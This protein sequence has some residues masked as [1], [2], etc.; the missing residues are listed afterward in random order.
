MRVFLNFRLLLVVLCCLG[1]ST[2]LAGSAYSQDLQ[3]AI[4]NNGGNSVRGQLVDIDNAG[5]V[6]ASGS[7]ALAADFDPGTPIFTLTSQGST[8]A[9]IQKLD[10]YGNFAWAKAIGGP[11]LVAVTAL[12]EDGSGNIVVVGYF[13]SIVD[14]DPG[15]N[16]LMDTTLSQSEGFVVKLDGNGDLLWAAATQSSNNPND[17]VECESMVLDAAGNI[18]VGGIFGGNIDFDPGTGTQTILNNGAVNAFVWKLTPGG[19]LTSV[20][21]LGEAGNA[22]DI[23]IVVDDPGNIIVAGTFYDSVD[24][25]PGPT[26]SMLYGQGLKDQFVT[27]LDPAGNHLWGASFGGTQDD[28]AYSIATGPSGEIVLSGT[29]QNMVDFDPGPGTVNR[30]TNGSHDIFT[31]KLDGNGNFQWVSTMGSVFPDAGRRV[32]VDTAGSVYTT[33][34]YQ[35]TTD[36]DPGPAVV[37]INSQGSD[38]FI[39]CLD[40]NGYFAWAHGINSPGG[41]VEEGE[42]I[43]VND[44]GDLA[45]SGYFGASMD[46]D[47]GPGTYMLQHLA[48]QD[49]F[50]SKWKASSC[51]GLYA[52]IDSLRPISCTSPG[53]LEI[54]GQGGSLPYTYTWLNYPAV[55]QPSLSLTN[56]GME[57][58]L[59]TDSTGCSRSYSILIPGPVNNSGFDLRANMTCPAFRIGVTTQVSIDAFNSGCLPVNGNL[60]LVIPPMLDFQGAIPA[61]TQ[62]NGDTLLWSVTQFNYDSGHLT[63]I[64]FVQADSNAQLWQTA[65][66]GLS[67]TYLQGDLDST[68]NLAN[69]CLPIINSYDPND[70][71]VLPQGECDPH[72]VTPDQ[73]LSY[74]IRFQNT[75]NADAIDIYILDTL[76][77]FLNLNTVRVI[78]QSHPG[79]ITEVLPGNVLKFRFDNIYLPDSA[80]DPQESQGYVM[81]ESYPQTGL[82]DGTVIEN[83]VGIYF[84]TNAPIITNT[85]MNTVIGTI[86]SL[87]LSVSQVND[88]LVAGEPG[89]SYQWIDCGTGNPV[90]GAT[91][92]T[93]TPSGPG[94]YAVEVTASECSGTSDCFAYSLTGR[95]W[96]TLNQLSVFPNPNQ[97]NFKVALAS[98][99]QSIR[100]EIF[101][102]A[103]EL[104]QTESVWDS[105]YLAV[106]T[107]LPSGLYLLKVAADGAIAHALLRIS[108]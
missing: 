40:V 105:D 14:L 33:G 30:T 101:S 98:T 16:T 21:M 31:L 24:V 41:S 9:Y 82:A 71:Q 91:G 100:V 68:N 90:T 6:Y 80:S 47:P 67:I 73:R 48:S 27:K 20:F 56:P 10:A 69:L 4:A 25:A 78:G 32:T 59:F 66:L 12:E 77:T 50:V 63:P 55:T 3:W 19:N 39:Q 22:Q 42:G 49:A 97:G 99:K 83:R 107:Q 94:N 103:G 52:S 95:S 8:D 92:Q 72:Y 51:T 88:D 44:Q 35:G 13:K 64:V 57:S 108:R 45:V 79:L 74:T 62:I 102:L 18:Y 46:F 104:V 34:Y 26:V 23:Q 70:K 89:A 29:F 43:A 38:V 106:E 1:I 85:V 76:S 61:P 11:D 87:D 53:L 84:D 5:N 60:Q 65:C 36:F 28:R 96:P 7:F 86:P 15:P 58:F 17:I 37:S 81:F 54:S 75:G 2:L 93:F